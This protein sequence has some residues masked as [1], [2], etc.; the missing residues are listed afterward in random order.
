MNL[1]NDKKNY[2]Y[3]KINKHKYIIITFI[4][5]YLLFNNYIFASTTNLEMDTN[6]VFSKD[7]EDG[8]VNISLEGYTEEYEIYYQIIS[9]EDSIMASYYETEEE[10]IEKA[11]ILKDEIELSYED[12][13]SDEY[14]E[15]I[16]EYNELIEEMNTDLNNLIPEYV[17][18]DWIE[19]KDKDLEIDY[20]LID[21]QYFVIWAKIVKENGT[22]VY[23]RAIYNT[24]EINIE[25]ESSQEYTLEISKGNSYTL[26][27][28]IEN[29]DSFYV[30]WE[31]EDSNIAIVN[32]NGKVYGKNIGET[33]IKFTD[34][35]SSYT[36][37]YTV[38]VVENNSF[39]N[40]STIPFL[41]VI[42]I[43]CILIAF[44]KNIINI[45]MKK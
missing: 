6:I 24:E 8:I 41:W 36:Q 39:L 27:I 20:N 42:G 44:R 40:E 30:L 29:V 34:L 16:N 45:M 43:I 4:I 14:N 9:I 25:I 18:S 7:I 35:K 17:E 21:D 1:R 19:L 37:E 26:D 15:K 32:E 38:I 31:S 23:N 28:P 11:S 33:T 12:I 22:I 5:I 3:R 10:Y 13:T 2:V